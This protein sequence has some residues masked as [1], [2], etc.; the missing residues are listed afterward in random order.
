MFP[1]AK[2]V[3]INP[4]SSNLS[5]AVKREKQSDVK[6]K[7]AERIARSGS[8][9]A[10]QASINTQI[11]K[12][13]YFTKPCSD[14]RSQN[15]NIKIPQFLDYK[16]KKSD[17]KTIYTDS[18]KE[19]IS[20][21]SSCSTTSLNFCDSKYGLKTVKNKD[22]VN[23][24]QLSINKTSQ[25]ALGN[26]NIPTVGNTS[27]NT[28][29]R[30]INKDTT[31][32][33]CN[34]PNSIS[35][36][37]SLSAGDDRFYC[38]S[39]ISSSSYSKDSACT[40]PSDPAA[41]ASGTFIDS[42][43]HRKQEPKATSRI[44]VFSEKPDKSPSS[45]FCKIPDPK[46]GVNMTHKGYRLNTISQITDQRDNRA[47]LNPGPSHIPDP[48]HGVNIQQWHYRPNP[49]NQVADQVDSTVSSLTIQIAKRDLHNMEKD[50]TPP[51]GNTTTAK[52]PNKICM[53]LKDRRLK[54][55]E[56]E[57]I[58]ASTIQSMMPF[59]PSDTN[60][61]NRYCKP[62]GSP[63]VTSTEDELD[64]S[65]M[66]S[67]TNGPI[68]FVQAS[69]KPDT[70]TLSKSL[71]SQVVEN[72]YDKP[73]DA[74]NDP[75]RL[76]SSLS[77]L[78]PNPSL[79]DAAWDRKYFSDVESEYA[80]LDISLPHLKRES[81]TEVEIESDLNR[82]LS[83]F[84]P[85]TKPIEEMMDVT[86]CSKTHS[87]VNS[88]LYSRN[89]LEPGYF[90]DTEAIFSTQSN[91]GILNG[92][93]NST[94]YTSNISNF[95]TSVNSIIPAKPV[96]PKGLFGD[97]QINMFIG[98]NQTTG[99]HGVPSFIQSPQKLSRT[100][101]IQE[102]K[103]PK[104]C[105]LQNL[106]Q[107][108]NKDLHTH[109]SN[110]QNITRKTDV[111]FPNCTV[112][113]GPLSQVKL[114]Y[115]TASLMANVGSLDD[116]AA[117]HRISSYGIQRRG[118]CT[119]SLHQNH[120]INGRNVL[121]TGDSSAVTQVVDAA[122]IS[123]TSI[124]TEDLHQKT[125]SLYDQ[126]STMSAE[127]SLRDIMI[128]AL[129]DNVANMTDRIEQLEAL[130]IMKNSEIQELQSIINHIRGEDKD[131]KSSAI[132]FQPKPPRSAS[133]RTLP[134][135][136][137]Q[138]DQDAVS[139][140]SV[141][142]G[143]SAGGQTM[144]TDPK[145]HDNCSYSI[146]NNASTLETQT[147]YTKQSRWLGK[148]IA[149]AFRKRTRSTT[150]S[151]NSEGTINDTTITNM[152]SNQISQKSNDDN[153]LDRLYLTISRLQCRIDLLEARHKKLQETV[154]KYNP[155]DELL[156]NEFR[157][158]GTNRK[159]FLSD[160]SSKFCKHSRYF[161]PV[162]VNTEEIIIDSES[163]KSLKI[164]C[165]GL[166]DD[167]TWN[168]LDEVL[169][170]LLQCYISYLDPNE[171]LQLNSLE[172]KAYQLN[173]IYQYPNIK[174]TESIVR[175]FSRIL[176][177]APPQP[178]FTTNQNHSQLPVT[179]TLETSCHINREI[180][181]Q[182]PVMWL[183]A[184]TKGHGLEY[185]NASIEIDLRGRTT[186]SPLKRMNKML[187]QNVIEKTDM[188]H[189]GCFTSLVPY[190]T[191]KS[192]LSVIEENNFIIICGLSGTGKSHLVNNL[193]KI[194]SYDSC[195]SK[196]IYNFRFTNNKSPTVKE[197]KKLLRKQLSSFSKCGFPKVINLFDMHLFQGSVLDI[198]NVLNASPKGP[199]I[200]GTRE[201]ADKDFE[202]TCRVNQIKIMH[203]LPD[204]KSTQEYLERVLYRNLAQS[205]M[206]CSHGLTNG[207]VTAS[208]NKDRKCY[209]L[210]FWLTEFWK[211]LNEILCS[212]TD[213]KHCA[214]FGVQS[215]LK[216]P[217]MIMPHYIGFLTYGTTCW[218]QF[219]LKI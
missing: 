81:L 44:P 75:D 6:N 28:C 87:P 26:S 188:L 62:T 141:A 129:K 15:E 139:L 84:L 153:Q 18:I 132:I 196:A 82:N 175:R 184:T 29:S 20:K 138:D 52:R 161:V 173:S 48:N 97:N 100:A 74:T 160:L 60:E 1:Y 94:T 157:L 117:K 218:F 47:N 70:C 114:P 212:I 120:H 24:R 21:K 182:F 127:V 150:Q 73:F 34:I 83:E 204:I 13:S 186:N 205:R 118:D 35:A 119:S 203:H 166:R 25:T 168:E 43:L 177:P 33:R 135:T 163:K 12:P 136:M 169:Q 77:K 50:P 98:R 152:Q 71:S 148:S 14:T 195:Y 101:Q 49:I 64:N 17:F 31:K 106:S 209:Q 176:P 66:I 27:Q 95:L 56:V 92:A 121:T 102:A 11:S 53:G 164:G 181:S 199:K 159:V 57:N 55:N 23:F 30:E 200:I 39:G 137:Y 19:T 37:F 215:T 10:S 9:R 32:K 86:N 63:K 96:V 123:N 207:D 128:R 85:C 79:E 130:E 3:K 197:I 158:E 105:S 113:T 126:I 125:K 107:R 187:H 58:I 8:C 145:K 202:N 167:M 115:P 99:S 22:N 93:V 51:L 216:C 72:P 103:W 194:L 201:S 76:L 65:K 88:R 206:F 80:A 214:I 4:P 154:L 217:W 189:Y 68:N 178:L 210:I 162:L 41:P 46:N 142:S 156:C 16:T 104:L 116:V 122:R 7:H 5:V 183:N 36:T 124:P 54:S 40:S 131:S 211:K 155:D 171:R 140:S 112:G 90:S 208:A 45:D 42:I 78:S 134:D 219:Y 191:L 143:T 61:S 185:F 174:K 165:V 147:V 172:L 108:E 133:C 111:S 91:F 192:Y 146:G 180:Y 190:N 179:A 89:L 109:Y 151:T 69:G 198:L 59:S 149:K 193:A 67:S 2:P 38:D 110:R 170:E 144:P 213:R